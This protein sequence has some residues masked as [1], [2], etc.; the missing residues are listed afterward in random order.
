MMY[1]FSQ[2]KDTTVIDEP[3]YGYYLK[4]SQADHPGRDEVLKSMSTDQDKVWEQCLKASGKRYVFL[5]NMAHHA[6][7]LHESWLEIPVPIFLIRDPEHMLPSLAKVLPSPGL[8]DTGLAMQVSLL[9]EFEKR[10]K[11]I[12]VIE[13]KDVLENPEKA[14]KKICWFFNIPYDSSM[15]RWSPGPIT[16]DGVWAKYWYDQVHQSSGFENTQT[17]N[18]EFPAKLNSLLEECRPYYSLL[19]SYKIT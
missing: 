2:R 4:Q 9:K 18:R 6:I 17:K 5:K 16:E 7:D 3:L 15:L 12:G 11:R 19:K 8:K 1:S 10:G 13:G 14:L